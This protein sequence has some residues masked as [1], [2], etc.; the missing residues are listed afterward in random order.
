MR[1][2]SKYRDFYDWIGPS[3]DLLNHEDN[4]VF[5]RR[6]AK[7]LSNN[8]FLQFVGESH[9]PRISHNFYMTPNGNDFLLEVGYIQYFFNI[10][11]VTR[12]NG[13]YFGGN[14]NLIHIRNE[15][16]KAFKSP[17]TLSKYDFHYH[18]FGGYKY[19]F[20]NIK[21]EN[22]KWDEINFGL[23]EPQTKIFNPILIKTKL[24]SILDPKE[25]WINLDQY[26]SSLKNEQRWESS[27]ITDKEKLINHGFNHPESFRNIK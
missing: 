14:I 5:D 11:N 12:E 16:K 21:I 18:R 10:K 3:I 22:T 13:I 25:I 1:I 8:D 23:K 4:I 15:N 9:Y 2:I 7:E 20:K 27:N 6:E 26:F 19:Y 17:I 24:T